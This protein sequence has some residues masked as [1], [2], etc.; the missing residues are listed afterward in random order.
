MQTIPKKPALDSILKV[1]EESQ[2]QRLQDAYEEA[3]MLIQVSFQERQ[4]ADE[5]LL[6]KIFFANELLKT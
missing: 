2:E 6:K 3:L 4:K 1:I 5:V